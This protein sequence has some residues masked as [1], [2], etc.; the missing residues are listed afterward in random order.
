MRLDA[1][2]L[3]QNMRET[4]KRKKAKQMDEIG[5]WLLRQAPLQDF[6]KRSQSEWRDREHLSTREGTGC[7]SSRAVGGGAGC[8]LDPFMVRRYAV[9]PTSLPDIRYRF[10]SAVGATGDPFTL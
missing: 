6:G 5:R 9:W 8:S 4:E 10:I 3:T 1:N 7:A 2:E